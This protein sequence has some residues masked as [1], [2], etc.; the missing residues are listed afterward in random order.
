MPIEYDVSL[1][2]G[3]PRAAPAARPLLQAMARGARLRCPA[4]GK[5]RLFRAYLK[6][7]DSCPVCH[8][9]LHHQRADDAPPYM[10]I[11]LVGHLVIPFV[12]WVDMAYEWPMW[13]NIAVWFPVTILLALALLPVIKGALVGLQWSLRM[14]GFGVESENGSLP[15]APHHPA[16]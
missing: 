9:E 3:Q 15:Y 4:C 1:A 14:H 7:A 13:V 11:F 6:V 16:T 2:E 10:T 12:L 5:G 8:E